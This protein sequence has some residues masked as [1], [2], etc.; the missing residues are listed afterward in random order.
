MSLM[1]WKWI[2]LLA[3][4]AVITDKIQCRKLSSDSQTSSKSVE[5]RL[6]E[7]LAVPVVKFK[8]REDTCDTM[9]PPDLPNI[10]MRYQEPPVNCNYSCTMK[11][12]G[13]YRL[14]LDWTL[15]GEQNDTSCLLRGVVAQLRHN[16]CPLGKFE[17][18]IDLY[19][20][21]CPPGKQNL[22]VRMYQL[23]KPS[24]HMQWLTPGYMSRKKLL[25]I[26]TTYIKPDNTYWTDVMAVPRRP[27]RRRIGKLSLKYGSRNFPKP[28]EFYYDC[29]DSSPLPAT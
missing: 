26:T 8:L 15:E 11:W 9:Q 24:A 17:K 4:V 29:D 5:A 20:Y 19:I 13:H 3:T 16:G 23:P 10:T 25:N 12:H 22:A 27:K 6:K 28:D 14:F 7:F 1:L 21:D 18:M 2:S